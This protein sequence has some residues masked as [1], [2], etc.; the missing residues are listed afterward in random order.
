MAVFRPIDEKVDRLSTTQ[1]EHKMA[2]KILGAVLIVLGTSTGALIVGLVTV[3]I[4]VFWG[5]DGK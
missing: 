5:G 2:L 1:A 4:Q 3:G